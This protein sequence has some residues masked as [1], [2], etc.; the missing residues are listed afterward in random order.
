MTTP[1]KNVH[2]QQ[3]Y[4]IDLKKKRIHKQIN[5]LNLLIDEHRF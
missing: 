4:S 5:I 2:I 3:R 1:L